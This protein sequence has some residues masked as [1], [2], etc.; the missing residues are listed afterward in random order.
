MN[1][2]NSFGYTN[3]STAQR[4]YREISRGE[5]VD[6][7]GGGGGFWEMALI[8]GMAAHKTQLESANRNAFSRIKFGE[9]L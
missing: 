6:D 4:S 2:F 5:K 3:I 7:T 8:L 1:S 9:Y